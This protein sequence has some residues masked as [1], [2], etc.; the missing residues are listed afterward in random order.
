MAALLL[1]MAT[2]VGVMIS[3][4]KTVSPVATSGIAV[5][6]FES[7]GADKESAFFA[8]AVY[9]GVSSKLEKLANLKVINHNSVTKYRGAHNSQEIGHDLNVAYVLRGNVQKQGA[10]IRLNAELIDVRKN[11]RV[12]AEQYDRN[13]SDV[14][15]L[16]SAIAQ[17]IVHKLGTRSSPAGAICA[18]TGAHC[19]S[20]FI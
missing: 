13:L 8:Y 5:L 1:A 6:P 3:K 20:H 15:A 7:L 17:T 19:G 18:S 4:A 11:A 9:D 2:V 16:Q 14:F 10:S 12:S